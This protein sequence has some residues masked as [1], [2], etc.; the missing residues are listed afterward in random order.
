[1]SQSQENNKELQKEYIDIRK[2][3]A[4]ANK[5][6]DEEA[7]DLD[8]GKAKNERDEYKCFAKCMGEKT[9]FFNEDKYNVQRLVEIVQAFGK[10]GTKVKL[11]YV[12]I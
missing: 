1:M 6:T 4:V 8:D 3:C 11:L 12:F 7:M 5:I 10:D 9:K 2:E